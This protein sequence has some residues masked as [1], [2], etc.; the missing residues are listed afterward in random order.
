MSKRRARGAG[1]IRQRKDGTWEARFTVGRDPGTGRQ[2]QKSVYAKTQREAQRLLTEQQNA[3]ND[4][5]YMEPSRITVAQWLD[6]WVDEYAAPR[7]RAGTL[8]IYR[9]AVTLHIKPA[10]GA[11]RLSALTAPSI[12]QLYNRL[13]R[14]KELSPA[15]VRK[16]HSVLHSALKKAVL[17]HYLQSNPADACELPRTVKPDI[18]PLDEQ[19]IGAFLRAAEGHPL[20]TLFFAALFTGMR[21]GELL[22]LSWD[23]IDFEHGTLTVRQQ[24]RYA[25]GQCVI[26]PTK[27]GKPRT[28]TPAPAVMAAL[29]RRRA[30]QSEQ[31]LRAGE[32][33]ENANDLVFTNEIGHALIPNTVY[34]RFKALAASIG[35][36][37][38]RFHDLRHSYAVAALTAGDEVKTVQENL[39]HHSAAF[40]LD[41]YA[42]VTERMKQRSADRMER[43]IFSVTTG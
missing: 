41:I 20:E 18:S 5:S 9:R 30:E 43:F 40:T 3:I 16:I 6:L 36:P 19:Q 7:V 28:L 33:W 1:M 14:E 37:N 22:G 23:C 25:N 38:A 42:H 32:L 4:G 27:S 24:L 11:I 15:T 26:L 21:E 12:Q 2:I 31:R 29:H 34:R 8:E 13:S 39:G 35:L 10:I 17:L